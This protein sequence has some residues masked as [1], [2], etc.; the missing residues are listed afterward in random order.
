MKLVHHLYAEKAIFTNLPSTKKTLIRLLCSDDTKKGSCV[1]IVTLYLKPD[2][3]VAVSFV[4]AV[5]DGCSSRT[6]ALNS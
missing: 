1:F 6:E 4:T 5:R 2:R 3:G